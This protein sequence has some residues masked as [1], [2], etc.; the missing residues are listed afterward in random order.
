MAI[1]IRVDGAIFADTYAEAEKVA[2]LVA[3]G[4]T[5]VLLPFLAVLFLL[6]K[7]VGGTPTAPGGVKE[8]AANNKDGGA[9]NGKQSS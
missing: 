1:H 9:E 3:Y 5:P 8:P 2:G 7:R 6:P 4:A